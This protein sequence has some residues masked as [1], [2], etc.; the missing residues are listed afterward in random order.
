VTCILTHEK[1]HS[2]ETSLQ[3]PP[4]TSG[5]KNSIQAVGSSVTYLCRYTLLAACGLAASEDTDGVATNGEVTEQCEWI[6]NAKDL[7]ELK[8]LYKQAYEK[9][10]STPAAI[11]QIIAAKNARRKEL[12]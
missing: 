9:F 11:K 5:S 7:D 3:G 2:E 8:K 6:S 4:D 1:G 12:E 10:E